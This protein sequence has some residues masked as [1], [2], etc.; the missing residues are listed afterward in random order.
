MQNLLFYCLFHWSCDRPHVPHNVQNV[1]LASLV[2]IL[3]G[4]GS[5]HLERRSASRKRKH[6]RH[7]REK[8][9]KAAARKKRKIEGE[10]LPAEDNNVDT[11]THT[12]DAGSAGME[13]DAEC[14]VDLP[15]APPVVAHLAIG[16]NEV[17]KRL[18][19]QAQ[20]RRP[21][22]SITAS[23]IETSLSELG[24]APLVY[25][26]VCRAD[27]DPQLLVG[28][29]PELVAS[30]NAPIPGCN[31]PPVHL[32]TLPRQAE[33]TL[34][35]TVGLRRVSVLA[36]DVRT[37]TLLRCPLASYHT[38]LLYSPQLHPLM[39]SPLFAL[40]YSHLVPHGSRDP[41]PHPNNALQLTF[42]HILSSSAQLPR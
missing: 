19:L 41:H 24:R 21:R 26:F 42:P 17:T 22:A 12:D 11:T 7:D 3:D 8:K 13:V 32:I 20:S 14:D 16:I 6:V 34:A 33:H 10:V 9:Q 30:C 31:S 18:E 36:L 29:L 25:V 23:T 38:P 37:P 2:S 35:E 1:A 4:V 27:I 15:Q 5:Y 39:R 40:M 28:H